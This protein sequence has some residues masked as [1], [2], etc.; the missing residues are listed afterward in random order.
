MLHGFVLPVLP[1]VENCQRS[2][3]CHVTGSHAETKDQV[4]PPWAILRVIMFTAAGVGDRA[5][6]VGEKCTALFLS[7]TSLPGPPLHTLDT[8]NTLGQS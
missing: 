8:L 6:T 4:F 2:V 5:A 3:V 7:A 1:A